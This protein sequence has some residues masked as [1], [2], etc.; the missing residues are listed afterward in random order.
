ML[1]RLSILCKCIFGTLEKANKLFFKG[2]QICVWSVNKTSLNMG[3]ECF[4]L[5]NPMRIQMNRL[6]IF[7]FIS[8]KLVIL[9][10]LITKFDRNVK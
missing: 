7:Q 10:Y 4:L 6:W 5:K 8:M 2:L 3:L 9:L 1:F